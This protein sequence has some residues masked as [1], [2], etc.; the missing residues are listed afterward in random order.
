MSDESVEYKPRGSSTRNNLVVLDS[1]SEL[2]EPQ[3]KKIAKKEEVKK[4]ESTKK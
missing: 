1:D 4:S 3:P 2:D